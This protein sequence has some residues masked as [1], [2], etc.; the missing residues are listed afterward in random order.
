MNLGAASSS[1]RHGASTAESAE[2]YGSVRDIYDAMYRGE[3]DEV[4]AA[5][6]LEKLET[7]TYSL[8]NRVA[9][10]FRSFA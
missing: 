3:I 9:S 7:R 2:P 5:E 1:P 8:R 10:L 4:Q 6:E